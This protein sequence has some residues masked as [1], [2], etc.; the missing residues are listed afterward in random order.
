MTPNNFNGKMIEFTNGGGFTGTFN[1]IFLL[2]DGSLY[3]NGASDTSFIYVATLDKNLTQQQ[4]D[5][6]IKLQLDKIQLDEPGNR[7]FYIQFK[8][9]NNTHKVQWGRN[10]VI[11]K[12][13]SLF[14]NNMMHIVKE[15][16]KKKS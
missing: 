8:N 12:N 1:S 2:E 9:G 5:N 3:R 10:P 6:Y 13:P 11:N 14:F 4:F 15:L 7:Y 16:E